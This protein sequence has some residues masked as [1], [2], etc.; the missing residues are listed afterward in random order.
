MLS[1][2]AV[3]RLVAV[4]KMKTARP[5][6]GNGRSK[7]RSLAEDKAIRAEY[8]RQRRLKYPERVNASIRRARL[9][10]PEARR[11]SNRR[12]QLANREKA[13]ESIRKWRRKY[14][15]RS[16]AISLRYRTACC[17]AN[18]SATEEQIKARVAFFGCVCS[19]CGGPYE[20]LDHAIPVARGGTNWPANLRPACEYCN[21]AKQDRTPQ[22]FIE[23][24]RRQRALDEAWGCKVD[25]GEK[26]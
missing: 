3:L 17:T 14:P 6:S 4:L 12:W 11:M 18:G 22:E 20:H 19:Y 25:F 13:R 8:M 23:W 9:K 5:K 15:E 7:S 1:W 10:N 21:S 26:P 2:D 16:R 24:R